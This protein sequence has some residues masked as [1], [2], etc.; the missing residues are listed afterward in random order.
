MRDEN[1]VRSNLEKNIDENR[2]RISLSG[3]S[4]GYDSDSSSESSEFTEEDDRSIETD[5]TDE[6]DE[7]I[8]DNDILDNTSEE[9]EEKLIC[10][11][12]FRAQ[13]NQLIEKFWPDETYTIT[14]FDHTSDEIRCATKFRVVR[15]RS[16]RRKKLI[17]YVKSAPIF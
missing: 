4:D 13:N 2:R 6:D 12:C 17:N 11:N 16:G 10:S 15:K 5:I 9:D 3:T 14:F 7:S 8:E 1:E